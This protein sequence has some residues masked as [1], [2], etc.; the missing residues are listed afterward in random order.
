MSDIEVCYA[1]LDNVVLVTFNFHGRKY[2]LCSP[3]H[4]PG[5]GVY[6]HLFQVFASNAPGTSASARINVPK[7]NA[8]GIWKDLIKNRYQR[9]HDVESV[10]NQRELDDSLRA[11]KIRHKKTGLYSQGGLKGGPGLW[12]NQGKTWNRLSHV[13]S[14]LHQK[15]RINEDLPDYKDT[16]IVEMGERRAV[17]IKDVGDL[18]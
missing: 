6:E 2:C 16:E 9:V 14:H 8:E 18:K 12:H 10:F 4:E 11:F 13:T 15:R 1:N 17:D 5:D 3:P 7:Q